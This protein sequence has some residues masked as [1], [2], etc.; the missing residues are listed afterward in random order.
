VVIIKSSTTNLSE[1]V[2]GIIDRTINEAQRTPL[3]RSDY[4]LARISQPHERLLQIRLVVELRPTVVVGLK[5]LVGIQSRTLFRLEIVR[6]IY[7]P[8]LKSPAVV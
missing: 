7:L 3:L 5:S 8:L 2:V 4:V 1:E 6:K